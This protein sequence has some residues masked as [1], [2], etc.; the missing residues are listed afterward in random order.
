MIGIVSSE[1]DLHAQ[2]VRRHL[3]S[4]GAS[5]VLIDTAQVP[6]QVA[7]T[8]TQ[9]SAGWRGAW[10]ETDLGAV[11]AM[12]WR[13]PEPFRLHDEVTD[14]HD[15]LF[16]RGEC[17]AM[18]S[19]LWSC[20]DAE[21]VNDPD[22]DEA[23]SRKM[24]QLALAVRLGLRVPRTCMTSDPDRARDFV[25]AEDGAVIFKPFSATP[26]TWRETRPVREC[27][28]DLMDNVRLAPVIFQELVPGGVD[29]RVTIV[30]DRVFAAEIR[31]NASSYEFDFRVERAPTITPH[32]L[33]QAVEARLL[34]LMRRLGLRYGAAD[35]RIAP[36]GDYVFL[37][38]NPAG[39]WLFVELATGQPITRTLAD[40]L[41]RLD[42]GEASTRRSGAGRLVTAPSLADGAG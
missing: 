41:H 8:S 24:A 17:A 33:P 7:L 12:W 27:D 2:G 28:L 19:G 9:D 18:V 30:G 34:T 32:T 40:L 26:Q 1:E 5:H 22:R 3:D 10:G 39:Q 29:V 23:A 13:R 21:W 15:R 6:M 16:A 20:M 25:H 35:L 31:G 11:H 36:D 14:P 4:I 38:V 42:Q 37:E